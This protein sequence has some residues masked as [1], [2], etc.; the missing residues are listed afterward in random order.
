MGV[1]YMKKTLKLLSNR[2][3]FKQLLAR[4]IL[5]ILEEVNA[6]TWCDIVTLRQHLRGDFKLHTYPSKEF[7]MENCTAEGHSFTGFDDR[8]YR[9]I[10]SINDT[11]YGLTVRKDRA[12]GKLFA[13]NTNFANNFT[14]SL[15]DFFDD[16]AVDYNR[17]GK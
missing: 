5:A 15:A 17:G 13:F 3:M 12:T 4:D 14:E 2:A 8:F 10:Q 11:G 1:Q 16:W 7:Y 6:N 9:A